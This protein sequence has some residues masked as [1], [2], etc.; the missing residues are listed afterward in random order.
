MRTPTELVLAIPKVQD[1][2]CFYLSLS[3]PHSV[4]HSISPSIHLSTSVSF[5]FSSI[6]LIVG[7]SFPVCISVSIICALAHLYEFDVHYTC[8]S[9]L[10]ETKRSPIISSQINAHTD[11]FSDLQRETSHA[12][13]GSAAR[14]RDRYGT[15]AALLCCTV[16]PRHRLFHR[17]GEGWTGDAHGRLKRSPR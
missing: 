9:W 8:I 16:L 6:L 7:S 11:T 3:R 15:Y 4:S 5:P 12:S 13:G 10:V 14:S 2:S 1:L 17:H